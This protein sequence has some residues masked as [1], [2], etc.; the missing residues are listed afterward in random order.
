MIIIII[1]QYVDFTVD[2]CGYTTVLFSF[3]GPKLECA[4]CKLAKILSPTLV[5]FSV[6]VV[7]SANNFHSRRNQTSYEPRSEKTGLRGF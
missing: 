4:T 1:L 6:M 2:K 5:I 7:A 3:S